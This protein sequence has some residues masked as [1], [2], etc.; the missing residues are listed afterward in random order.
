MCRMLL[1]RTVII[2][3]PTGAVQVRGVKFAGSLGPG[4]SPDLRCVLRPQ[5]ALP[6]PDRRLETVN[7]RFPQGIGICVDDCDTR[8]DILIHP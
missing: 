6:H 8:R 2:R 4:G 3:I 7:A 1:A 5:H